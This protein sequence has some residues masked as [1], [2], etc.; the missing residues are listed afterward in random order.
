MTASFSQPPGK[1]SSRRRPRRLI[2]DVLGLEDRVDV[3]GRPALVEGKGDRGAADHVHL[4]AGT[5]RSS[6]PASAVRA[7]MISLRSIAQTRCRERSGMK[8]PRRRKAAGAWA[9]AIARNPGTS[10][11]N[12]KRSR[13]RSA[14]PTRPGDSSRGPPR[15][16]RPERRGRR[17]SGG[18]RSAPGAPRSPRR[19]S[20]RRRAGRT[21]RGTRARRGESPRRSAARRPHRQGWVS[22]CGG[23]V[24][25]E[26]IGACGEPLL[27]AVGMVGA[28]AAGL[29]F[30]VDCRACWPSHRWWSTRADRSGGNC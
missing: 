8:T 28:G 24:G 20:D 27:M 3:A 15:G 17:R 2:D 25:G 11:T 4:G 10:L 23:R 9:I 16:A 22:R 6:S 7:S 18:R 12:Q 30:R 19:A 1:P 14:R 5:R 26:P 29:P 21:R 13:K